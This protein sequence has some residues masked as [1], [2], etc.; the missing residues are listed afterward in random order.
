MRIKVN[1]MTVV[2]FTGSIPTNFGFSL[3]RLQNKTDSVIKKKSPSKAL[4]SNA[5]NRRNEIYSHEIS[6]I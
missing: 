1:N 4:P 5:V 2:D 6:L 3:V